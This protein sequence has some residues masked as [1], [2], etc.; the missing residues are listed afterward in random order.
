MMRWASSACLSFPHTLANSQ[1][2]PACLGLSTLPLPLISAGFRKVCEAKEGQKKKRL[3]GAAIS[4]RCASADAL[5]GVSE[6]VSR[7]LACS[8]IKPLAQV[9][10][11]AAWRGVLRKLGDGS[12]I[13]ERDRR[14]SPARK[15]QC[16]TCRPECY[17]PDPAHLHVF[18]SVAQAAQAVAGSHA[19]SRL[20]ARLL[21]GRRR[22]LVEARV[23]AAVDRGVDGAVLGEQLL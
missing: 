11:F 15:G 18:V 4:V 19:D 5:G 7:L 16:T 23:W 8:R 17:S 13:N 12:G 10:N 9:L 6:C 21:L 1:I 2:R 3:P 22:E 14:S 20:V